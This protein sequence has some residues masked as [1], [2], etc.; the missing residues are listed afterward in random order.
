MTIEPFH[1]YPI[2]GQPPEGTRARRIPVK[3]QPTTLQGVMWAFLLTGIILIVPLAGVFGIL[4]TIVEG[5]G[6]LIGKV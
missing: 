5:L 1:P 6:K 2:I 3:Y 4:G